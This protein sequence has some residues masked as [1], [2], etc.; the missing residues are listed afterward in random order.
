MNNLVSSYDKLQGFSNGKECAKGI[1]LNIDRHDFTSLQHTRAWAKQHLAARGY[2]EVFDHATAMVSAPGAT[3][4]S[5]GVRPVY[6]PSVQTGWSGS[7]S[8]VSRL[9]W[10]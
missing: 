6:S 10:R 3:E 2:V 7:V 1:Q 5:T 4:T 9:H 8:M